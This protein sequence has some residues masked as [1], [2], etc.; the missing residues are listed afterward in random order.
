MDNGGPETSRHL[1]KAKAVSAGAVDLLF[2][3]GYKTETRTNNIELPLE[4]ESSER[5][6]RQ[7]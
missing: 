5:L 6:R 7:D 4:W 1:P 2:R 3:C